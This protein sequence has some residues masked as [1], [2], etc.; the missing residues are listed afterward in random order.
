MSSRIPVLPVRTAIFGATGR[1]GKRL[2][3]LGHADP[4]I[5][6]V[7]ACASSGS[8]SLN[9]DAGQLAG[10]GQIGLPVTDTIHGNPQVIIDFSSPAGTLAAVE[11]ARTAGCS[12]VVATTGLDAAAREAIRT[13]SH[14]HPVCHSPNMSLAVNLTMQLAASAARTLKHVSADV[15]VEIIE[16]HHR[17][18][19]DSPSGTALKFGELIAAALGTN[20]SRH[21]RQGDVGQRPRNEIGY[22]AV[23]AGDDAGQHTI[24][25]GMLGELVELRVAASNRDC[26]AAGAIA[27]AKFLANQGPGMYSM[28]DVLGITSNS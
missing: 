8:G 5:M 27:A 17:Y 19:A 21:G 12:L 3:A 24:L 26:Y 14:Q 6:L 18:K 1:V 7:C 16:R 2:I 13:L 10:T 20:E 4:E 9:A 15:D 22:H 11:A 28:A 25:F 23:R